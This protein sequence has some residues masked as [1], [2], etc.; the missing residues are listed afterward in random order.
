MDDDLEFAGGGVYTM[1][2]KCNCEQSL[3]LEEEVDR[4]N[5]V[6][7]TTSIELAKYKSDIA[8]A[9]SCFMVPMP[10]P[11]TDLAKVM[12]VNNILRQDHTRLEERVRDLEREI[13][14]LRLSA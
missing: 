6:L 8:E 2:S 10:M 12:I 3:L 13:A 14:L 11:N 1:R 7:E 5:A 9:S 4:L